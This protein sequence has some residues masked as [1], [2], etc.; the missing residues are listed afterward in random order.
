[1]KLKVMDRIALLRFLPEGTTL[2]EATIRREIRRKIEI[3]SKD[4][5]KYGIKETDFC[6]LCKTPAKLTWDLDNEIP[7][8][9]D[10]EKAQIEFLK[11][12]IERLDKEAK[13]PDEALDI[14]IQIKELKDASP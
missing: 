3:P 8:D 1:M 6:P 9:I 5:E 4:Y 10:F 11:K 7:Q 13:I 14:C 12:Q 2:F